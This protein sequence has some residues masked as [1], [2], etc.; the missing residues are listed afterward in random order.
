VSVLMQWMQ[1]VCISWFKAVDAFSAQAVCV[2]Y[3]A[4]LAFSAQAVCVQHR[5]S[6]IA[7]HAYDA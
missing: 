3:N 5:V 1:S 6:G 2:C 7:V 4:V